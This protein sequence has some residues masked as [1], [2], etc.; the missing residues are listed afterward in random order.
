MKK[1]GD[2][3]YAASL[4]DQNCWQVRTSK[5]LTYALRHNRD[6]ALG[7]FNDAM[8]ENIDHKLQAFRWAPHKILG[9]LLGN[10]KTRFSVHVQLRRLA[11]DDIPSIDWYISLS[12]VQGCLQQQIR[13][14]LVSL[15]HWSVAGPSDTSSTRLTTKI[16]RVS[17]P[18]DWRLARP[19][20][21]VKAAELPSTWLM[22]V[23][24]RHR[25]RVPTFPMGGICFIAI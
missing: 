16:G 8:F 12:A 5:S 1:L 23:E 9:F 25:V 17:R 24:Q 21:L 18:R 19:G 7:R 14:L 2:E 4:A 13:P 22:P 6:L 3:S 11:Y 15:L 20:S 10:T